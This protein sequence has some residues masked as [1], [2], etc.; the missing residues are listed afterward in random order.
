MKTLL[1]LLLL[2]SVLLVAS[3]DASCEDWA[4][5]QTKTRTFDRNCLLIVRSS[6]MLEDK[7]LSRAETKKEKDVICNNIKELFEGCEV[8][9]K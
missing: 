6:I 2:L 8:K 5:Y 7:E 1:W 9:E 4:K 3:A